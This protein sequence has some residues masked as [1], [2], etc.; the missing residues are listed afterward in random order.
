MKQL[1]TYHSDTGNTKKL[2]QAIYDS[3]DDS[4]TM[5][6]F[7]Q[8]DDASQYD[9][10]FIGFP[11]HQFGPCQSAQDFINEKVNK[12]KVAL[13]ATHAMPVKAPKYKSIEESCRSAVK[14]NELLGLY[15]CQG[16][17]SAEIADFLLNSEDKFLKAFGKKRDETVGHPNSEEVSASAE[18]AINILN[19][20]S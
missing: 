11:I 20:I 7:D 1:I 3:I 16:E 9:V 19:Q 13:F 6:P 5:L 12:K 17:L 15:T 18:F 4:K 14:E 8:V 2:A 10:I